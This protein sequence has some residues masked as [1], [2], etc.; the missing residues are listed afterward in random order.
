MEQVGGIMYQV[1]MD[2]AAVTKGADR[3]NVALDAIGKGGDK[4]DKAMNDAA[5]AMGKVGKATESE[6]AAL[7][8]L[9]GQIDPTVAAT[10]RLE[11]MQDQLNAAYR[12]GLLSTSAYESNLAKL[13]SQFKKLEPST[14]KAEQG[15]G[16]F[17]FALKPLAGLVAG[18]VSVQA[19]K[20]VGQL[21]EQ[22][23]LLQSRIQ[24]LTPD[25]A[26]AT[27]T[28]QSLLSIAGQT[29]Q[30]MPATVKLWESLTSSLKA[31]GATNTEVL[32]LTGT[33]QKIGKIGG[34]SAEET[35]NALRQLGQS[36]A[37]GTLRAEE[38]NS[39]VEQ[40]PELVR[41]LAAASGKS[42]GE[43]RQAMLDG[44]ITSQQLFDLLLQ[45]VPAVNEEFQKLPRSASDAGNAVAVAFGAAVSKLDQALGA[46]Q[47]LAKA[48]DDLAGNINNIAGNLS[49]QE[50]LNALLEDQADIQRQIDFQNQRTFGPSKA[51]LQ[52]LADLQAKNRDEIELTRKSMSGAV[53][54]KNTA[55]RAAPTTTTDGQKAIEQL[56]EQN[57]QMRAQGE[58]RAKIVALQ[59]LG[60]GATQQE[61]DLAVA[62]AIDTYRLQEAEKA[63]AKAKTEGISA[64]KKAQAELQSQIVK[65]AAEEKRAN[66]ANDKAIKS[67]GDKLAEAGLKGKDLAEYQARLSLNPYATE[68]QIATVKKL[69]DALY[70]VQQAKANKQLLGQVDPIAGEQQKFD[71][72]LE[73]YQKLNDAK[74][75]SDQRYGELKLQAETEH[76]AAL[77][78]LQEERFRQQSRGNDLLI[79]TLNQLQ[80]ASAQAFV[81]LVTG[82]TSGQDAVKALAGAIL[83]E[84]VSAVVAFG[85]AQLKSLIIG[86]TAGAAAAATSIGEAAAVATA[87]ATPAALVSLASFGA[88]SVPASAGVAATVGVAQGLA[89]GAR[90]YGGPV[91][92]SKMYRVNETGAP[93][94]FNA[95]GG[96][97]YMMPNSRGEVVSNKDATSGGGGGGAAP[98]INIHE[99]APGSSAKAAYSQA[100]ERW[101]IDVVNGNMQA[102]GKLGKTA[103][104]ITGTRRKGS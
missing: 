86:Q 2:T 34:S 20:Q 26:T 51:R 102:G 43:F 41:Q 48:L 23:T 8:K 39:I 103:N 14:A 79:G 40:T 75:L 92:A 98:V 37:G 78:A 50:K 49:G 15:A 62:L 24:R 80:E 52:E 59:K 1:D 45:R 61:R 9:L 32:T 83:N 95:A 30:T 100:D 81:G 84:A 31:L 58:E 74:L 36:L 35:A 19:L 46:S 60:Q 68:E 18:V 99:A 97:Q 56:A 28:Y 96:K 25:L 38:Y 90:Q 10:G 88:N 82:A 66:E 89:I 16:G 71:L 93:E 69:A 76:E 87:W 65:D 91:D 54:T 29:G 85:F 55:A 47:R 27:T 101:V 7:R 11:D 21:A 94:I 4:L 104:Q 13:D 72:Q 33:L 77:T 53:P 6:A 12:R 67:L 70:D 63:R 3:V 57:A 42:M 17:G 64:A 22:F 5:G 44:K 73:N